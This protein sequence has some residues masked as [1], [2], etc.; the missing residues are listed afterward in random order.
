MR[1]LN[2]LLLF[3]VMVPAFAVAGEKQGL[4]TGVVITGSFPHFSP[5][6]PVTGGGSSVVTYRLIAKTNAKFDGTSFMPIDSTNYSYS[7]G[8]GGAVN[9]D[10]PYN[11]EAIFF[12]DSYTYYYNA[13]AGMYDNKLYRKQSFDADNRV[14]SLTYSSW[15]ASTAIWKDSARY[16]YAYVPG[17]RKIDLSSFELYQGGSM[18]VQHDKSQLSYNNDN[19]VSVVSNSYD[20]IFTYDANNNITSVQD[21]VFD[22]ASGQLFNNQR[23]SYTYN[24]DNDVLTFTLEV[25]NTGSSAWVKSKYWE[26]TYNTTTKRQETSIEYNWSGGTWEAYAKHLYAFDNDGKKLSETVMLWNNTTAGY[27]N[28]TNEVWSYNA[29]GLVSAIT[30]ATWDNSA[31]GWKYGTNNSQTRYYYEFYF[32]TVVDKNVANNGL[33]IY[34]VPANNMVNLHIKWNGT[35]EYHASIYNL[36]GV[37]VRD[38]TDKG[39]A[40]YD[41]QIDIADLPAGNYFVKLTDGQSMLTQPLVVIK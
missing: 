13:I 9:Q 8:R 17:T 40:E 34:P 3:L 26:Y 16:L 41:K 15:R 33:S 5:T 23:K 38:W 6:Q 25:W 20:A 4:T 11:D 19:V 1:Q 36:S 37:A 29:A 21:K 10:N 12:D 14:V 7:N 32:P 31:S 24:A 30:T 22:H 27:S 2:I 28:Y 35:N 39:A 18:W